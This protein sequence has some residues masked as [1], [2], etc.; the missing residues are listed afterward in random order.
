MREGVHLELPLEPL[1]R[2][3]PLARVCVTTAVFTSILSLY[4]KTHLHSAAVAPT[5]AMLTI[6][7]LYSTQ[8]V[9]RC[10]VFA[11][12]AAGLADVPRCTPDGG[13]CSDNNF[14]GE[15]A[16]EVFVVHRS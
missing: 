3:T 16:N 14:V 15:L 13:A 5:I 4:V 9:R 8:V 1:L 12:R 6:F 2:L 7:V 10:M 11:Q